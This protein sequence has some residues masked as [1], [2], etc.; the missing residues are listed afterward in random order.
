MSSSAITSATNNKESRFWNFSIALYNK[1]QV[2]EL[3]LE[4][5]DKYGA[6]INLLLWCLWLEHQSI[7]L[8]LQRLTAA[9]VA[10]QKWDMDYVQTLRV[11]RRKMKVEF[12]QDINAVLHVREQIKSAELLAEKCEQEWLEKLSNDWAES[13]KNQLGLS[14][15][16]QS[17]KENLT[18]Y[19]DYLQVPQ[20]II[21]RARNM[22]CND[23]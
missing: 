3:C 7:E 2:T 11:L 20:A 22:L 9:L 1:P 13:Q 19:L 17:S 16:N 21:A 6:N 10:I 8:S 18:F 14:L 15:P 12:A 5:Q 23:G 4:L